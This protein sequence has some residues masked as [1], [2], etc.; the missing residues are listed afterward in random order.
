[1]KS[2]FLGALTYMIEAADLP[3]REVSFG[4]GPYGRKKIRVLGPTTKRAKVKAARKAALMTL[5]RK[6][7]RGQKVKRARRGSRAR[8]YLGQKRWQK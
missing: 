4:L 2:A 1:M 3:Y 6:R 8:I 5:R 7:S